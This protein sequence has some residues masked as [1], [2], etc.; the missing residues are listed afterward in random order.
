MVLQ[1]TDT[2]S[3]GACHQKRPSWDKL[4]AGLSH[5]TST[6]KRF[7]SKLFLIGR[8]VR[9]LAFRYQLPSLSQGVIKMPVFT[10]LPGNLDSEPLFLE[11]V[12]KGLCED[13]NGEERPVN[14]VFYFHKI[15]GG[16]DLLSPEVIG[17]Q[18]RATIGPAMADCLHEDYVGL[19][20]ACRFMDDPFSPV[21]DGDAFATG[22]ITT[23]RAALFNAVTIGAITDG[24]GKHFRSGKHFSPLAEVTVDKDQINPTVLADWEALAD[25]LT[26]MKQFTDAGGNVWQMVVLSHSLC[27]FVSRPSIFT[28][29]FIT[30]FE[31]NLTITSMRR[32]RQK[33]KV[34]S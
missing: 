10:D 4:H 34:L 17:N 26:S 28:G 25:A 30:G 22:S 6:S 14:N 7:T 33:T 21:I 16:G 2:G 20:S 3:P 11:V 29:A 24:R 8:V 31:V 9:G 13:S 15:I 1:T 23:E 32:R 12:A 27:D 18:V 5:F 19:P